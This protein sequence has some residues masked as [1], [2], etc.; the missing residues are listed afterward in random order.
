L[1]K[2]L[3]AIAFNKKGLAVYEQALLLK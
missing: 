3:S 2:W 1:K